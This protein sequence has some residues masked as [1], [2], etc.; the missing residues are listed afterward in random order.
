MDVPKPHI[1]IVSNPIDVRFKIPEFKCQTSEHANKQVAGIK[2][3]V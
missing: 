3:G 2:N 1:E